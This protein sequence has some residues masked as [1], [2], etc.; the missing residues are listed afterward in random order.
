MGTRTMI[1]IWPNDCW[2]KPSV[3]KKSVLSFVNG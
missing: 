2:L 3:C 1:E